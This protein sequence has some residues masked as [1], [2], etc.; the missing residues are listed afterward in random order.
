M[1]AHKHSSVQKQV[2]KAGVHIAVIP[3][4]LTCELQPLDIS[5]NH[6]FKWFMRKEWE[7]W[8]TQGV[9]SFT[10][11]GKQLQA[12]YTKVCNWIVA[13]WRAVKPSSIINGF[14]KAGILDVTSGEES[15]YTDL[16]NYADE[17]DD[18][19]FVDVYF[20]E[21][22]YDMDF[23]GFPASEEEEAPNWV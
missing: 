16:E 9:H 5:V 18:I 19:A 7:K 11:S 6:S 20:D 4:G 17:L 3:G 14:F 15:D 2:N 23:E 8:M 13:A 21:S 12:T 22:S 1:A 10:P